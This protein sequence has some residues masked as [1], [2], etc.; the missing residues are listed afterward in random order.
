LIPLLTGRGR[1][2]SHRYAPT[3]NVGD[4][5]PQAVLSIY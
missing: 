1:P 2:G 3:I 4:G 5:L